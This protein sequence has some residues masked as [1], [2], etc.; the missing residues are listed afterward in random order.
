[1]DVSTRYIGKCCYVVVRCRM[2]S[3][4]LQKTTRLLQEYE[5]DFA[6]VRLFVTRIVRI[7]SLALVALLVSAIIF[8]IN[9]LAI[10]SQIIMCKLSPDACNPLS[11]VSINSTVFQWLNFLAA[12]WL[13]FVARKF[14]LEIRPDK[15]RSYMNDRIARLRSRLKAG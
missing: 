3:R 1:V 14:A 5:E 10:Y 4:Q 15:Y 9:E 12:F 7:S 8:Q 6:D 11:E 2:V 13:V